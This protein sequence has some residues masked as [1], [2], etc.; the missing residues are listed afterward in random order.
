LGWGG[1]V[2]LLKVAVKPHINNDLAVKRWIIAQA[3]AICAQ[4]ASF[5]TDTASQGPYYQALTLCVPAHSLD[6]QQLRAF[7]V[8]DLLAL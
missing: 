3:A 4:E 7:S 8:P 5:L 1:A 6:V 2:H